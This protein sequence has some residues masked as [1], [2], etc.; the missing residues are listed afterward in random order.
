MWPIDY[1]CS[2][3]QMIKIH[4]ENCNDVNMG[5]RTCFSSERDTI[6]HVPDATALILIEYNQIMLGHDVLSSHL[7]LFGRC[8]LEPLMSQLYD[9]GQVPEPKR[10]EKNEFIRFISF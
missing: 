9:F 4:E 6:D 2:R 1:Y 3:V 8:R 5:V 10:N 7:C